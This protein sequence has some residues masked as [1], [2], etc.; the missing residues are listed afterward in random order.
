MLSNEQIK[1]MLDSG[2]IEIGSH[3]LDHVNLPKLNKEEKE[4]QTLENVKKQKISQIDK[5]AKKLK[6][7]IEAL[8]KKE[9]LELESNTLYEKANLILSNLHNIKPYQKSL[10]VYNYED[11][12]NC[13]CSGG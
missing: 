7:T 6:K 13:R 10:N 4:K 9:E 12:R 5:K 2:L 11:T 3:T 8:P 1:E